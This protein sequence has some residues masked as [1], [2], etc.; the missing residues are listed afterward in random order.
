MDKNTLTG[1]FLIAIILIAFN[2]FNKPSEAELKKEKKLQDSIAL[3]KS[4]NK[5]PKAS[6]ATKSPNADSLKTDSTAKIVHSGAFANAESG[7][8]ELIVLEN[9]LIKLNISTKGGKIA[10]AQLKK[11]KTYGG[12]P[13][14]LMDSPAAGNSVENENQFGLS[15]SIDRKSIFTNDLV[16][17]PV[18]DKASPIAEKIIKAEGKDSSA[19]TLRLSYNEQKYIDYIYTLHGNSY[20][21]GFKIKVVGFE[22]KIA[23]DQK[24]ITLNWKS[25]IISQE[26][27]VK[28]ESINTSVY[29]KDNLGNVE[30][31][32]ENKDETKKFENPIQWVSFKQHFFSV[33][34]LA[35]KPFTSVEATSTTLVTPNMVKNFSASMTIPYSHKADENFGMKIYLGPNQFSELTKAGN[36]LEA[37]IPLGWGPLKFINRYAVM[38]VFIALSKMNLNYGIVILL[39]TIILKLVLFPATYKSY[40]S[41]A[42][43]RIIK[44]EMDEIKAKIGESD[45]TRLQQEYMKLYQKAGINPLGGCLPILLQMPILFSVLRFFPNAFEL[46]GQH[47]LFMEDLSTYDSVIHWPM[48]I[49]FLGNHLSIMCILMSVTTLIYSLLNSQQVQGAGAQY[50]YL[51]YILPIFSIGFLNN[52]SAGL[53]YYYFCANIIT[54]GQQ[55][56]IKAFVNDDEIHKKIQENKK[57]PVSNKRSKFQQQLE[58]MTKQRRLD[59][60]KPTVKNK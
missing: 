43:M 12:S 16:F 5:L 18:D 59:T 20:V 30:N 45:P 14:M 9:E 53:N 24:T 35:E 11:F 56:L 1:M 28:S 40:L 49:P 50:K 2:Y 15:L 22:D 38:P 37:S 52:F 41:T 48:D 33:A 29:V 58:E 4:G 10:S 3:A 6:A 19:L 26:K 46:R 17:T 42:K 60:P 32:N 54:F 21:M 57:K 51:T 36:D 47:F 34:Y 31:L 27:D 7:K 39:L 55:A 13:L 8:P 44:P 23:A 25:N